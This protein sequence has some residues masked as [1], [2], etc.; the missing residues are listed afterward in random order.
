MWLCA[1]SPPPSPFSPHIPAERKNN[2]NPSHPTHCV[3]L[4]RN[5]INYQRNPVQLLQNYNI[6]Q[7]SYRPQQSLPAMV[8]FVAINLLLWQLT[9]VL[10]AHVPR[11]IKNPVERIDTHSHFVPPFWRA[12]SVKHGYGMPDGMPGIPVS[13][14]HHALRHT[15]H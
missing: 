11:V 9:A 5:S 13:S 2:G 12:E 10:A 4:I 14:A 3:W 7:P 15:S 8:L 6:E 1:E